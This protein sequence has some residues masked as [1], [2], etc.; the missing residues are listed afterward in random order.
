MGGHPCAEYVQAEW[1]D[2][3]IVSSRPEAEDAV[4]VLHSCSQEEDRAAYMAADSRADGKPVDV[5]QVDVEQNNIRIAFRLTQCFGSVVCREHIVTI[6]FKIVLQQPD[7]I[8]F[9]VRN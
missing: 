8:I 9:I 7:D 4:R 3:I 6:Y 1:F 5:R 2:N